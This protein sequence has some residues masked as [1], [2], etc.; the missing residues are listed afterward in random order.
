MHREIYFELLL[1]SLHLFHKF[2]NTEFSTFKLAGFIQIIA[3]VIENA[4]IYIYFKF[5][6]LRN[7][8][9]AIM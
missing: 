9:L 3:I 5:E 8:K 2:H 7:Q 6:I 1:V 4:V